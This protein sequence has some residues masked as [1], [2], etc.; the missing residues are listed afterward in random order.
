MIA[1]LICALI[2]LAALAI[3]GACWITGD[4]GERQRAAAL[5]DASRKAA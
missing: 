1:S 2:G 4:Q 3:A 5:Q